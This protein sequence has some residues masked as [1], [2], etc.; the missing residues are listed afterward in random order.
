MSDHLSHYTTEGL[1]EG[2]LLY[3]LIY[4]SNIAAPYGLSSRQT[5]TFSIQHDDQRSAQGIIGPSLNELGVLASP[6]GR[7]KE[8]HSSHRYS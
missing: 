5:R 6:H 1:E 8:L 3:F 2:V 4:T 7:L